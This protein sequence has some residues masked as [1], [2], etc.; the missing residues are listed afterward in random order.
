MATLSKKGKGTFEIQF[1]DAG[2]IRKTVY[3]GRKYTERTATDLKG[4]VEKLLVC[5]ANSADLDKRATVWL[6]TASQEIQCK[7][8]GVGLIVVP[9]RKTLKELWDAF[10]E[11][12]S[13]HVKE[14]TMTLYVQVQNRFLNFFKATETLDVLNKERMADWKRQLQSELAGPSVASYL[15][16]AKS[17]LTWAVKQ[18]WIEKS[19]LDG[20][21]RGSFTNRKKDRMIAMSEYHR[22]LDACPCK[23]WRCTIALARIGGLRAPSEV[24]RLRWSDVNW[25][26]GCFFVRSSK[27]E[28]HEG[29]ANRTV[30]LFPELKDELEGLF[31]DPASEK[32]EY[33]INRFR[34]SGQNLGTLF[35]DIVAR[36]GLSEIQRPFDNMRMTRSNE[37]LREFGPE[38]ES[39]W[40]GHSRRVMAEHYF[41]DTAAD[42]AKASNWKTPASD[43]VG[44]FEI[45]AENAEK[46]RPGRIPA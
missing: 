40:I 15:K 1:K 26:H 42:Y 6:E 20:I 18:G 22:L 46:T 19:P 34:R 24:V 21:G 17:C 16:Q 39:K 25:E 29:K 9:E 35:D 44:N 31:F 43:M 4:I 33:V 14:S 38:L 11:C 12:K 27:T 36:A 3:L 32:K 45:T 7:L 10:L 5:Q 2:G 37:V 8:A 41:A 13:K 30:P 28:H 23:D